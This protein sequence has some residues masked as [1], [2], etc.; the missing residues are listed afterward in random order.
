MSLFKLASKGIRLIK[1][2]AKPQKSYGTITSNPN[3]FKGV[4][5]A[6]VVKKIGRVKPMRKRN[7]K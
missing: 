5:S 6:G 3:A 2:G 7:K 4:E 1:G